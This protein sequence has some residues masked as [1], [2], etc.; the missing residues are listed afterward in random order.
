MSGVLPP[1]RHMSSCSGDESST[2]TTLRLRRVNVETLRIRQ[3]VV[4][5]IDNTERGESHWQD[6]TRQGKA[7]QDPSF[8]DVHTQFFT[9]YSA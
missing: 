8:H 6:K 7:R 3:D 9:T 5:H 2:G 4:S 1:L